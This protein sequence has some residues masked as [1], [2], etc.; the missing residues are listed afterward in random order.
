[1][2]HVHE[3][4]EKWELVD[5]ID[6]PGAGE[7]GHPAEGTGFFEQ[8]GRPGHNREVLFTREQVVG[9]TVEIENGGVG[10]PNDEQRRRAHRA[11]VLA[12]EVGASST[13]DDGTDRLGSASGGDECRG[14]AGA[15]AEQANWELRCP[16][17]RPQPSGDPSEAVGQE[18][19]VEPVLPGARVNPV[20]FL[21]QEVDQEGGEPAVLEAFGD[22]SI[23]RTVSTAPA[24]VREQDEASCVARAREVA[25]ELRAGNRNP[26]RLRAFSDVVA[27]RVQ[28][29]A[30]A[31][32]WSFSSDP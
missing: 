10:A 26:N 12:R 4:L 13:R 18:L 9:L 11:E 22:E 19:D 1:M 6:E 8:V 20:L 14:T 32:T 25:V 2:T 16:R 3:R 27:C 5:V 28:P 30:Q 23:A 17:L 29:P 21:R 24:A 31:G 15:R 7:V